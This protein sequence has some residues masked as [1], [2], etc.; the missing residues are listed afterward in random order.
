MNSISP[1]PQRRFLRF[2]NYGLFICST[3]LAGLVAA[4]YGLRSDWLAAITVF[5]PWAWVVVGF[6]LP[7]FRLLSLG[8]RYAAFVTVVWLVFLLVFADHPTALFRS[9]TIGFP[10]RGSTRCG[11]PTHSLPSTSSALRLCTRIIA[12]SSATWC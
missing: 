5:P 4:C 9:S 12:W 2:V 7:A 10:S 11:P 3:L 8:R 1:K 6:G